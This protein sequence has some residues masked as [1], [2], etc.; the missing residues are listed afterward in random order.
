VGGAIICAE[1]GH[2]MAMAGIISSGIRR[3]TMGAIKLE[4]FEK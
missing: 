3:A 4:K 1:L 2:M